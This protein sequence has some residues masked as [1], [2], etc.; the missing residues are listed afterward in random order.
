MKGI[1]TIVS[2]MILSSCG[3]GSSDPA[4]SFSLKS[5][6]GSSGGGKGVRCGGLIRTLD[7]YEAEEVYGLKIERG[8][9][10]DFMDGLFEYSM[11]TM[12]YLS[13]EPIIPSD[14]VEQ[15]KQRKELDDFILNHFQ[16]VP[17][18]YRLPFTADATLPKLPAGCGFIQI[19]IYD[20]LA[21][22]IY[23]DG[24]YWDQMPIEEKITL[25]LHEVIYKVTRS[26]GAKLSDDA[27][28]L[29][30]LLMSGAQL[31]PIFAPI[32][33]KAP[34]RKDCW[35]AT[36]SPGTPVGAD[37]VVHQLFY[38]VDEV[39]AGVSGIGIYFAILNEEWSVSRRDAFIP[40]VHLSDLQS[41]ALPNMIFDITQPLFGRAWKIETI[42]VTD[43]W[44]FR[45]RVWKN[46]SPAG[47]FMEGG[48]VFAPPPTH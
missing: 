10:T 17:T 36:Q 34:N 19:A 7:A 29:V 16:R 6:V 45:V 14:P 41:T 38:V 8:K 18:G 23:Y 31:E 26:T 24:E 11:R 25:V 20:D 44:S 30:G 4:R 12:T 39:R 27:R 48:C 37:P 40:N 1:L 42:P 22:M 28:R 32:M 9:Y 47:D 13:A 3:S 21:D 33:G 35:V 2:I 15:A 46:G 5:G 43:E